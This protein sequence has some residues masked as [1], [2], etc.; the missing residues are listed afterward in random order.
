VVVG[1][2]TNTKAEIAWKTFTDKVNGLIERHVPR[3]RR[4][5][6]KRPKWMNVYILR[7]T[8]KKKWMWMAVKNGLITE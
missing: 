8:L 1:R 5:N 7:A 3:R 6:H 2:P 4:R